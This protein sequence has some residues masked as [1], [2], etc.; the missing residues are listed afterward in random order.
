[1]FFFFFDIG[2]LYD[3]PDVRAAFHNICGEKLSADS[4][5][6]M[7]KYIYAR[8]R[9]EDILSSLRKINRQKWG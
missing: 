3:I 4:Y 6:D 9:K 7:Q 5:F 8:F 2:G 1:M